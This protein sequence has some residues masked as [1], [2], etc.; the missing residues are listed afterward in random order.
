MVVLNEMVPAGVAAGMAV[1]SAATWYYRRAAGRANTALRHS[2]EQNTTL[3]RE[4]ELRDQEAGHLSGVRLPALIA[5]GVAEAGP[6][7]HPHLA[8]TQFGRSLQAVLR[9]SADFVAAVTSR[10]ETAAQT[11]LQAILGPLVAQAAPPLS[12]MGQLLGHVG[13][14]QVLAHAYAVDHGVT[15]L[16]QRMQIIGVL[17]GREVSSHRA[18]SPLMEVLG[19]AQS[20]VRDYRRVEITNRHG[21]FV[22]GPVVEPIAVALAE[23]LENGTRHSTPG[24]SVSVGCMYAH[25][26]VSIVVDSVGSMLDPAGYERAAA[27]LPGQHRVPLTSLGTRLGHPAVGALAR[28]SGFQVWLDP[29]HQGGVR[30]ILHLPSRLLLRAPVADEPQHHGRAPD[31]TAA[32]ATSAGRMAAFSRGVRSVGQAVPPDDRGTPEAGD[33]AR[34]AQRDTGGRR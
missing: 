1:A 24:S 9:Q 15:L 18:D 28:R 25:G 22:R 17:T 11:Q 14:E 33:A 5:A 31:V 34:S 7:L 2:R 23:L 32:G 26:G 6:L 8:T 10:T 3:G 20:R 13:D 27:V 30:A 4:I 21:E 29:R 16:V 19:G 12:A